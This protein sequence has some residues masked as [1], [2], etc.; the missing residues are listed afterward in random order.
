MIKQYSFK[1]FCKL[2]RKNGFELDHVKGSH[3]IFKKESRTMVVNKNLNKM[4]CRRLIKE[5]ELVC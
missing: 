4:V 5:F 1:E 3:F 2:I